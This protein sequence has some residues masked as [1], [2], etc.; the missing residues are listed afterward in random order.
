MG[1]DLVDELD[2]H[3]GSGPCLGT[4]KQPVFGGQEFLGG[5]HGRM[6]GPEPARPVI[7]SEGIRGERQLGW[8]QAQRDV[9]GSIDDQPGDGLAVLRGGETPADGLAGRFGVQ[10]GATPGRPL[11]P[12][13]LDYLLAHLPVSYT[14]LRAHETDSY[15]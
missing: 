8:G 14:H 7:A 5:E 9:L 4:L 15:L 11:L 1:R 13:N 10:V 6:Q 12:D 3:G 2:A